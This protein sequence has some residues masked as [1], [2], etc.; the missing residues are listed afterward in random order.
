MHFSKDICKKGLTWSAA[1]DIID[2]H[3]SRTSSAKPAEKPHEA[4]AL[5]ERRLEKSAWFACLQAHAAKRLI[6]S[7]WKKHLTNQAPH[8]ILFKL[9]SGSA[10]RLERLQKKFLTKRFA[11]WYNNLR[12]LQSKRP[13]AQHRTLK[14]KQRLNTNPVFNSVLWVPKREFIRKHIWIYYKPDVQRAFSKA[15]MM[16]F[17]ASAF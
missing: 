13:A 12:A 11:I 9:L 6:K 14:I 4:S 8:G 2:R 15:S 10:Y 5:C 16:S 7:F 3:S 1:F 17:Q